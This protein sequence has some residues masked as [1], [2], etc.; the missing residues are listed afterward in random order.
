MR[1][2][3]RIWLV[4]LTLLDG[5]GWGLG[6]IP[7]LLYIMRNHELRMT[8]LGFRGA[9]GPFYH[10]F[11]ADFVF[12]L[13]ITFVVVSLFKVMAAYWL[14]QGRRDGAMLLIVLL[15]LS[16]IF[17]YGFDLP[18]GPPFGLILIVLLVRDWKHLT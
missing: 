7:N 6:F 15:T 14:W 18:F 17:W 3:L 9:E 8:R 16:A 4:A 5:L 10:A 1:S 11:G 13:G 2:T 12:V